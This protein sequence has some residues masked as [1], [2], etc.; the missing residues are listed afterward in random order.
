MSF[1]AG[2][3]SS[4]AITSIAAAVIA[5][6]AVIARPPAVCS[7]CCCSINSVVA[8][9]VPPVVVTVAAAIFIVAALV[10]IIDY[11]VCCFSPKTYLVVVAVPITPASVPVP[12]VVKTDSGASVAASTSFSSSAVATTQEDVR[13]RALVVVNH[14]LQPGAAVLRQGRRW[15]HVQP[16]HGGNPQHA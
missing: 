14:Q 11:A 12:S 16:I 9:I 1:A 7:C 10:V 6:V 15:V 3:S 8:V 5:D 2:A 13:H 4:D